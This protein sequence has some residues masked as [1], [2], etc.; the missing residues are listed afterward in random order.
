MV[1]LTLPIS[2][3][4]FVFMLVSVFLFYRRISNAGNE[5]REAE[6]VISNFTLNFGRNIRKQESEIELLSG[7]VHNLSLEREKL[8][9]KLER[10][11]EELKK[12]ANY[13]EKIGQSQSKLMAEIQVVEEELKKV[14][15]TQKTIEQKLEKVEKMPTR[16]RRARSKLDLKTAITIRRDKALAPLTEYQIKILKILAA[17]GEKTAPEMRPKIGI[18]REH[19][20]R[21]MRRLYDEGYVERD[22]RKMPYIYRI[23]EEARE[24][25]KE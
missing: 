15:K 16:P 9:R 25:L 17:E 6:K 20:S 8:L 18:S 2:V 13:P 24:I 1:D 23:K 21:L 22:M 10:F 3:G 7:K 4:I 12:S 14:V 5:H 19:T 11:R